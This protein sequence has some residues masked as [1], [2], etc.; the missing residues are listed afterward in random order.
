MTV[1]SWLY[2]YSKVFDLVQAT[3]SDIDRLHALSQNV[4]PVPAALVDLMNILAQ[5]V[6]RLCTLHTDIQQVIDTVPNLTQR[7]ILHHHFLNG[8][9]ID[10]IA[11][12]LNYSVFHTFRLY[13]RALEYLENSDSVC[14]ILSQ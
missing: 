5:R 6:D 4:V 7:A 11:D 8:K 12:E 13:R 1:K 14:K 3:M 9:T 10:V 2:Q